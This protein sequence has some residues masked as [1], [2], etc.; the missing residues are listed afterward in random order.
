MR[1]FRGV[2][3][4]VRCIDFIWFDGM[5]GVVR[6]YAYIVSFLDDLLEERGEGVVCGWEVLA[7]YAYDCS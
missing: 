2:Y 5:C 1:C 6:G 4:F 7:V 3:P